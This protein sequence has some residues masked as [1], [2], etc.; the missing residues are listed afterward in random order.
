MKRLS[1]LWIHGKVYSECRIHGNSDPIIEKI[2]FSSQECTPG[3]VFVAFVGLHVDAHTYIDQAIDR[4]AS[5]VIHANTLPVYRDRVVYIQH[6]HPRRVASLFCRALAEP[7]PAHIIGVTGTDGKSSTCEFLW[8]I[9]NKSNIRCGLLTTVSIDDG[10]GKRPNPYR[11]STPEV[12]ILYE[13]LARCRA[14]G[15]DTVILEATSHGLSDRGARLV[16][17]PFTG[18][19]YTNITSEHLEFHGD[20]ASY[21][22]AKM[23]LARQVLP[24][25]TIIT[26]HD[27][28]FH[29]ELVQAASFGTC[30]K[31]Y[32]M[33]EQE[34]AALSCLTID[35]TLNQRTV[36]I[37]MAGHEQLC[38]LPYG[39]HCYAE[40][41]MGALLYLIASAL[42][43]K[44]QALAALSDL[45]VIPGRFELVTTSP[46]FTIIID[47]A[48]TERAFQLLFSHIKTHLP[49]A[50]IIA[51]FG[52]AGE[53]DRSKRIPM[54][55]AAGSACDA[56]FLTDEDPRGEV[57]KTILDDLEAG[58]RLVSRSIPVFRIHD[59]EQAIAKALAYCGT[60][61]VLLLLAKGH[62]ASIAYKDH[63]IAW[64]ERAIVER[65]IQKG[66]TLH[67]G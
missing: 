57:A 33:E 24:G 34:N 52:A 58:I 11:Q 35:G 42:V 3:S 47:F 31:T 13:F 48:H 8:H 37:K 36:A 23:N 64:N 25:G 38:T 15:V 20:L 63:T 12:P 44:D 14:H 55:A 40:N 49:N 59:R 21:V 4:G 61:D 1:A 28:P 60:G 62:E 27:F 53:R 26:A 2:T 7:L 10:T 22:D 39:Q 19:I 46:G 67:A 30:I 16:D 56:C 17:I 6:P 66:G 29:K 54:G 43:P 5:V 18:A 51:L 45:P 65:L 32:A 9:L 41:A 50:R